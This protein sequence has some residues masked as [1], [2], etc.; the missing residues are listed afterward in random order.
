LP[1][2]SILF[3][4][5]LLKRL[6]PLI[7]HKKLIP[8]HQFGF[9][10]RHS[11]I[12]QTH[13]IVYRINEAFE[14]EAYCSA[15]VLDISQSL[16]QSLAYRIFVHFKTVTPSQLLPPSPIL[17]AKQAFFRQNCLCAPLSVSN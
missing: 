11:T 3:E 6:L 15:A 14:H 17:F 9:R 1:I 5:L 8:T 2:V 4:K 12:E 7:E 16:W 10:R 13:R